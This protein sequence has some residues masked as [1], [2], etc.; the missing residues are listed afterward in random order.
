MIPFP[1]T[2]TIKQW[3]IR[4]PGTGEEMGLGTRDRV[5]T[6][7]GDIRGETNHKSAGWAT[8]HLGLSTNLP[9]DLGPEL[10]LSRPWEG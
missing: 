1:S 6:F 3:A 7:L 9:G 4:P 10:F 8:G 5:A 2:V